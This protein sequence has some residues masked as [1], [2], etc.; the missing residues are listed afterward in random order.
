[1][2][3]MTDDD[4][5]MEEQTVKNLVLELIEIQTGINKINTDIVTVLNGLTGKID[6]FQERLSNLK[7]IAPPADLR[8]LEQTVKK[9][10]ADIQSTIETKPHDV[11]KKFEILLFPPQDNRLLYKIVFGNW[12]LYLVI[13]FAVKLSF[14]T[15]N[16]WL[17]NQKQIEIEHVRM[18]PVVQAWDSLY[19]DA[20]KPLQLKMDSTL[21]M[22]LE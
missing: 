15:F 9:A 21:K 17:D 6:G 12:L 11:T 19:S 16:H 13:A 8:P 3:M 2:K 4:K 20:A 14:N 5:K 18:H 7:V 1:M 10:L 22:A